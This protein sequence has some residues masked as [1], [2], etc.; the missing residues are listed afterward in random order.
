MNKLA[1]RTSLQRGV[2]NPKSF[3]MFLRDKTGVLKDRLILT[4]PENYDKSAFVIVKFY[5]VQ[6]DD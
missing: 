2:Y 6:P 3:K 1:Q 4:V 5:E